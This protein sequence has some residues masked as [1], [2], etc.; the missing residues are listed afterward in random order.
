M[1][2]IG[3]VVSILP[4]TG[5]CYGG[6]V[7]ISDPASEEEEAKGWCVF[8]KHQMLSKCCLVLVHIIL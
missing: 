4:P 7:G 8:P 5:V 1:P 2:Q 6:E 3:S